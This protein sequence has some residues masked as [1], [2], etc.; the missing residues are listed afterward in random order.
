MNRR[1]LQAGRT[2]KVIFAFWLLLWP[3]LIGLLLCPIRLGALHLALALSLFG[4]WA[5]AL[6]LGYARKPVRV[7]CLALALLVAGLLLPGR[8]ADSMTLRRAYAASLQHYKGTRYLW[9][10]GNRLGID[11][12]GPVERG[13]IDADLSQGLATINPHLLRAGLSLWWHNRSAKALGEGYRGETRLL[14]TTPSLN[15][16]DDSRLLPGDIAVTASGAHTLA[17][18]GDHTWIEADPNVLYGDSVVMVRTPTRNAW[19]RLPMR[20]MRWRQ[21]EGK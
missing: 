14:L 7:F 11:C 2:R 15:A 19:F 10:G 8:P 18:L 21:L 9:G 16:L 1:F 17:Y 13:L 12:S 5:G 6:F 3:L 20:L 4:L